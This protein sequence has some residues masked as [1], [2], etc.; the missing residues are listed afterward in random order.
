MDV[1][2][3]HI[4]LGAPD[5][6]AASAAFAEV[7][8]VVPTT[9]G[10]HPGFG[11]RNKLASIGP[12]VFWEVMA[13]DP[14]QDIKGRARAEL[15]AG[16]SGPALLTYCVQTTDFEG[17]MARAAAAGLEVRE[18]MAMSRT[19]PD[20]VKLSWRVVHFHH[21]VFG[22]LI[23]FAIDWMGSPHPATTSPAGCVLRS[24][25]VMHP[26]AAGLSAVYGAMG[27]DVV[28]QGGLRGGMVAVLDTSNGAVGFV[29]P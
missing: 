13:P 21:P 22:L 4:L 16:W 25:T 1:K 15:I 9:G 27:L 17:L 29:S 12:D 20:G 28:V 19:R 10:S 11:T 7:T 5:L 6:D 14:A 3:D 18:P 26:D 2:L 24:F 23:P 8:G